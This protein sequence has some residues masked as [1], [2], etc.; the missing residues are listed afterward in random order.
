[1]TFNTNSHDIVV[2]CNQ[3]VGERQTVLVPDNFR[4]I[5]IPDCWMSEIMNPQ[6]QDNKTGDSEFFSWF[7]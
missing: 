2:M 1:M 3:A 4:Q 7:M 6:M 5:P